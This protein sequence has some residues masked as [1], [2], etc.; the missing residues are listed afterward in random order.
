MEV[1]FD[2]DGTMANTYAQLLGILKQIRPEVTKADEKLFRELGASA[3]RKILKIP[4]PEVIKVY[5]EVRK[6]QAEII[7]NARMIKGIKEVIWGLRQRGIKVGV[8]TSNLKVNVEKFLKINGVEVDWVVSESTI[9][10][11]DKA[12]QKIKTPGMI[13][14]GD[15]VRDIEAC[16]KAGIKIIAVD[17]GVNSR[18]ALEKYRPDYLV[19]KPKEIIDVVRK[20]QNLRFK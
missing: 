16:K 1:V 4:L 11:K 12:L 7:E 9:F 5:F 15:E 2:F 19:T 10:G 17:W 14:I 3:A 18:K 13:Y 20:E 6:K 8:L